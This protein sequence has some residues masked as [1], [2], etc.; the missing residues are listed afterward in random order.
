MDDHVEAIDGLVHPDNEQL[1]IFT[2]LLPRI[3]TQK[4][5]FIGSIST[6]NYMNYYLINIYGCRDHKK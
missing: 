5:G 4:K 3:T 6:S 1:E 2:N